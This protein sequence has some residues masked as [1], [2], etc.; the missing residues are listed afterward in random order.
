MIDRREQLKAL[1]ISGACILLKEVVKYQKLEIL[2][3]G[4]SKVSGEVKRGDVRNVR[5]P[6]AQTHFPP[7]LKT[8]FSLAVY[9][10]TN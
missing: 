5:P 7:K 4:G 9:N 10:T 6:T 8:D 3:V 2:V 1:V